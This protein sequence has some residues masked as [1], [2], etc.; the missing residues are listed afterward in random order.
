[1]LK[2]T[3]IAL[4]KNYT[5]N[6]VLINKLWHEV[7]KNYSHKTRQYHTL[8]H[9]DNVLTQLVD[10]KHDIQNWE[11]ILFSLFYHDIIYNPLK[12]DNEAK[13]AAMAEI[14][15]RETSVPNATI[16]LCKEQILATKSHITSTAGDTNFFTDADLSILGNSWAAYSLYCKHIRKEYSIYPDF[17]YKPGRKKVLA[18]FLM[19]ER[20]FKTDY[21]YAKFEIQARQNIQREL[22]LLS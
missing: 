19:M 7:E 18:H 13:S 6:H 14:R 17:V 22:A 21:F 11:S 9:L 10:V 15:M 1:M 12:S 5:D 16:E 8:T 2:E 3:F 20:L 4:L